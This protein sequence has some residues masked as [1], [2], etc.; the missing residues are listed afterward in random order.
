MDIF[1]GTEQIQ[2]LVIGDA[3]RV[4]DTAP[5]TTAGGSR[6]SALRAWS[7]GE[8]GTHLHQLQVAEREVEISEGHGPPVGQWSPH[9]VRAL[10]G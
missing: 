8:W 10:S 2:Q 1:E 7:R 6:T 5:R 4:A 3:D 9:H